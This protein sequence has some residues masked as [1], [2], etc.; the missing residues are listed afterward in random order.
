MSDILHHMKINSLILFALG[1]SG[2]LLFAC[3]NEAFGKKKKKKPEVAAVVAP[4]A[5]KD[6]VEYRKLIKDSETKKGLF[7][8]HFSKQNKRRCLPAVEPHGC[9]QQYAGFRG[10]TD[11]G[12]ADAALVEP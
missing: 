5:N 10:G 2:A 3:P 7:I 4:P 9:H 6:S 12:T 11:G 1:L 8:T